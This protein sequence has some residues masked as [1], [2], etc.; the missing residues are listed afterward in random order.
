MT[1]TKACPVVLRNAGELE[2]LAFEH[3]LAGLQLVKGS[4][5][6]NESPRQAAL[7]ELREESGL[8]ATRIVADLGVWEPGYLGQIWS[9]HICQIPSQVPDTWTH[10]TSDD[11]GHDFKFFWHPLA[12]E[13][14]PQWH[15]VFRRAL[16]YIRS[17]AL[18]GQCSLFV[19]PADGAPRP[20][21]LGR[22]P[23]R[24]TPI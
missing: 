19:S 6:P 3:P 23:H 10:R 18:P 7:R 1:P 9:F 17:S 14:S 12:R 15:W 21:N 11:G 2:V 8:Q 24:C 4:I 13:A 22:Q 5:E 20:L 16:A